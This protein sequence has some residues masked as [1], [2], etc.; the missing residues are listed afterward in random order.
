MTD[1]ATNL[2][3]WAFPS[4]LTMEPRT[5]LTVWADQDLTQAGLHADFKL[6]VGGESV[7]LAYANGTIV[8]SVTFNTQTSGMGYA[9]I[10]NGSGNFVIQPPTYNL[11]NETLAVDEIEAGA[12]LKSFPNP[13]NGN[14]TLTNGNIA[15]L[16]YTICRA[17]YF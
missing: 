15:S 10:P 11:N 4:G 8:E 3:K 5:Y 12:E 16:P 13:T 1:T 9:R 2:V 6:L 17:N 7:L 14:L